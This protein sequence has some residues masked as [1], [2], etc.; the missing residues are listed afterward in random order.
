MAPT[1]LVTGATAGIGA[2]FARRLAGRG[3]DLVL[4]ARDA[5]R[6]AAA[7]ADL[8]GATGSAVTALPADLSDAA[9][10]AA[11]AARLADADRPVDLLVNNAGIGL[12]GSMLGNPVA[13]EQ[14][15]LRLNVEAVLRLTLAALPGM[16][17]RRRGAVVNVASVA[18]FGP[19]P[20]SSYP[21]SKAWVINFSESAHLQVR[22]HGVRVMALCPGFVRTEFHARAAIPTAGIPPWAWLDADRVVA[23][24]LRDLARGRAVSVPDWRYRI[25]VGVMRHAP[26]RLAHRLATGTGKRRP[27][28]DD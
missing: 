3:Y 14:R 15:M 8:A 25:A 6:L 21:A 28:R 13:D 1:A 10:V 23:D 4:V 17:Q 26:R 18:G 11:V 16:R 24:A 19:M 20:G 5:G 22:A 2:A 27:K 12:A 7:A 9:G